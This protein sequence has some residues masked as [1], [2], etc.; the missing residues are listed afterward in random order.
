MFLYGDFYYL[1]DQARDM[2]LTKSIVVGHTLTLIGA[3]TGLGGLFHGPIWLY[4]IAPFFFLFGGNPF[5]TL[6]PLFIIVSLTLIIL[7]FLVGWR[8]Y[9][10]YFGLLL[11]LI[12]SVSSSLVNTVVYTSNAHMQPIVVILYLFATIEF[13]RGK[14]KFIILSLFLVGLGF[15][16]ESAF[17][18]LLI[19]LTL[20]AVLLRGKFPSIKNSVLGIVAFLIPLSTFI[21]FDLRH[22]F[23]MTKSFIR[24]FGSP[25]KPL[26]GYEQY[27][28]ITFRFFD[29]LFGLRD[30]LA[31]PLFSNFFLTY[32]LLLITFALPIL[33]LIA[34]LLKRKFSLDKEYLFILLS[35]I[36]IFGLYVFYPLPLWAHY[37]LPVTVFIAMLLAYS[38][39]TVYSKNI[40]GK[41]LVCV[42]LILLV[43]PA[44]QSIGAQYLNN[45]KYSS[46]SD[47]SYRNQLAVASWVVKDMNGKA[48]GY[49]VYSPGILTYNMD[50]L[51]WWVSKQVRETVPANEKLQT[52]YLILYPHLEHDDN[53]YNY[54]KKNTLHTNGKVLLTKTFAGGIIVEKL[55]IGQE[56]PAVDPN[57]FQNLIFR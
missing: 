51:I 2:L 17:A 38:I 41:V 19:A 15:Q 50:Y 29:R 25:L 18:V 26:P 35:P 14:D 48:S 31:A 33:F 9:N 49:F 23:L 13:I 12:L 8:L 44:A 52:T 47:G 32:A 43:I 20:F 6:V 42:F 7:G 30:S 46:D 40:Y 57:Y 4:I 3:R 1:V 27:T 16:F 56:E 36:I 28:S 39:K 21:L 10:F 45:A 53:A 54:W 37:L 55:S 34:N 22:Q 24:L 5:L 11:A